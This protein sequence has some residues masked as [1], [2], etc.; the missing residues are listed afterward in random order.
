MESAVVALYAISRSPE[1]AQAV[2]DAHVLDCVANLLES[3]SIYVRRWT[4]KMLAKLSQTLVAM[5]LE[6]QPRKKVVSVLRDEDLGV[7]ESALYA[8]SLLTNSPEGRQD[9]VD[10]NLFGSIVKL[11]A[12]PSSSDVQI[13]TCLLLGQLAVQ[14]TTSAAVL[15]D[16]CK[17]LVQILQLTD[18]VSV[19]TVSALAR[20]SEH[21][22]G[23]AA[24]MDAGIQIN[25][26]DLPESLHLELRV[27]FLLFLF[28]HADPIVVS[29]SAALPRHPQPDVARLPPRVGPIQ[30]Y[31]THIV[32]ASTPSA[33]LFDTV[34]TG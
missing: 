3:P 5:V 26:L 24:I 6:V 18:L 4:C 32:V 27:T 30:S 25:I 13:R 31:A 9:A 10:A 7:V 29:H 14:E 16:I 11:L 8:F 34:P 20:I 33:R 17:C 28:A 1:G 2:V 19:C 12:P 23:I 21:P 22:R 15:E